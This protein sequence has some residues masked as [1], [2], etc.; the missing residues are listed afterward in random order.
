MIE[1][2]T[3][4]VTTTLDGFNIR[5]AREG[6]I[7]RFQV[8]QPVDPAQHSRALDTLDDLVRIV[9]PFARL[10]H[11]WGCDGIGKVIER[12]N[13][14]AFRNLS[15]MGPRKWVQARAALIDHINSMRG[16]N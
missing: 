5:V 6:N 14:R 11:V 1:T 8:T 4:E 12:N 9:R 7:V 3:N 15:T 16:E 2:M 10:T 13:G